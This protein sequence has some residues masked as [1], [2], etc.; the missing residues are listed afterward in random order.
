MSLLLWFS[1][2]FSLF[3]LPEFFD[4]FFLFT[5]MVSNPPF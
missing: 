5:I 2:L 3:L 1:Y 4:P